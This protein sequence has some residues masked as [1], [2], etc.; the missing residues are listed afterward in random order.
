MTDSYE[1]FDPFESTPEALAERNQRA[2]QKSETTQKGTTPEQVTREV[3]TAIDEL[4]R[5]TLS[6][7]SSSEERT[8]AYNAARSRLV[9]LIRSEALEE[10]AR[11]ADT[12]EE[13]DG[14][15]PEAMR[16]FFD[17][18]PVGCLRSTVRSTKTSITSRI[19]SLSSQSV[20]PE[21]QA[22]APVL[23]VLRG[24][25]GRFLRRE[26]LSFADGGLFTR[27]D[28]AQLDTIC[29]QLNGYQGSTW[30]AL[31]PI[32]VVPLYT[33]PVPGPETLDDEKFLQSVRSALTTGPVA[34]RLALNAEANA[35]DAL[36][37]IESTIRNCRAMGLG[38]VSTLN[39]LA[40]VWQNSD[41]ADGGSHRTGETYAHEVTN[42]AAPTTGETRSRDAALPSTSV[43]SAKGPDRTPAVS[44]EIDRDAISDTQLLDRAKSCVCAITVR[45]CEGEEK[46]FSDSDDPDGSVRDWLLTACDY[47]D[48]DPANAPIRAAMH[49]D[50]QRQ[51]EM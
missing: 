26:D 15:P 13:L 34:R 28:K 44:P 38:N 37:Q 31:Q 36:D 5:I 51:E 48:A 49:S 50:T 41:G 24:A 4:F 32:S 35:G 7:F 45:N 42:E 33:H 11:V 6:G 1:Q 18:D 2:M 22:G 19:R 47:S 14:E 10:A 16:A 17:T 30:K 40:M 25:D 43:S 46:V 3:Q 39:A 23:W 12:E 29:A 27:E 21:H 9:S 20:S 8:D